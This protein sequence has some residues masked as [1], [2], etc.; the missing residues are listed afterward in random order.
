[1]TKKPK[2]IEGWEKVCHNLNSAL[3][4]SIDQEDELIKALEAEKA[5]N[6]S[7]QNKVSDL[8]QSLKQL[9]DLLAD[10]YTEHDR[11]DEVIDD[12]NTTIIKSA[13]IINYLEMKL[14]RANSI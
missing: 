7:L 3:K 11:K 6:K 10:G 5:A 12:M 14:D 13:G 9:A 8:E 1:M 2:T 4:L